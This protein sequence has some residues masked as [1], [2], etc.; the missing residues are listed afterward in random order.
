[1]ILAAF[2]RLVGERRTVEIFGVKLIG[3]DRFN[4]KRLLFTLILCVGL[5]LL[6]RII[7]AIAHVVSEPR[8]RNPQGGRHKWL[9]D[10]DGPKARAC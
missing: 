2:I 1:M 3:V 6:S 5:F 4:A 8:R 7:K 9:R 10:A